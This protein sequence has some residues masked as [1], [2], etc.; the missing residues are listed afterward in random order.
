MKDEILESKEKEIRLLNETETLKS[1]NNML[2]K[3]IEN[4]DAVIMAKT[5]EVYNQKANIEKMREDHINEINNLMKE[6]KKR[7]SRSNLGSSRSLTSS[8]RESAKDG[9]PVPVSHSPEHHE[10]DKKLAGILPI[11]K[12]ENSPDRKDLSREFSKSNILEEELEDELARAIFHY[13]YQIDELEKSHEL[14][15]EHYKSTVDK[16]STRLKEK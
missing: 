8:I 13:D 1:N 6:R 4:K 9:Q 7:S 3:D 12:E 5:E 15:L 14:E 10:L 2:K 11:V 16:A